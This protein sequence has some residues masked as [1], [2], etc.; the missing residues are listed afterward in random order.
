MELRG[1]QVKAVDELRDVLKKGHRK[2]VMV[3]PTGSGKTHI[4]MAIVAGAVGKGNKV[5]VLVHR[6]QLVF[7]MADMFLDVGIEAGILMAGEEYN[8]GCPVQIA[9]RD[10]YSR[11]LKLDEEIYNPFFVDAD[12]VL[13]DESH[14]ALSKTYQSILSHYPDKVVIGV[15]ATPALSSGVGMGEYF[16]SLIQP[17]GVQELIEQGYLVPGRYFGPGEPDLSDVRTVAGD[18]EK[19]G[20]DRVMNEPILIGD[21]VE[22]WLRIVP[23]LKTMVF[24][25][26]VKHSKALVEEYIRRGVAAEHLDAHSEDEERDATLGRFR[27][28]ETQVLSN[29][30][31]YTE[32]T[33]IPEIQAISIARPTK[34]FGLYI[35]M[36]GRGARPAPGKGEFVVI[37]HGGCIRR[38]GFYEDLVEWSLDGKKLAHKKKHEK[39][40]KKLMT[41]ERCDC[42]FYG[43]V[44]TTCGFKV[45]HYSKKIAAI[46]AELE[47]IGRNK[48]KKQ[49]TMEEKRQFFGM[50]EWERKRKGYQLGWSAHKFRERMGVWPNAVKDQGPIE[51]NQEFKNY[52]THLRIKWAKSKKRVDNHHTNEVHI[53]HES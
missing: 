4:L 31:L 35:Q 43:P 1:Y 8:P 23:G 44:C 16:D 29:V 52:M 38:L 36:I 30:A 48:K 25:V 2:P 15:T 27:S 37:D 12:V 9:S 24:A 20:L 21:V 7:Q 50:L 42:V 47:E 41:C 53:E 49:Y 33:N 34:S 28:G 18:Y 17:V 11:R 3:L 32:G 22:N 6:R 40:E 14:H 5:A 19:K 39:K 51:P 13:I 26:N 45:K 10:T 46:D